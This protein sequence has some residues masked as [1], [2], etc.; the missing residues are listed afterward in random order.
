MGARDLAAF[1][2]GKC[3]FVRTVQL[4][5]RDK[6]DIPDNFLIVAIPQE[7]GVQV[8]QEKERH[9]VDVEVKDL[10]K[11]AGKKDLLKSCVMV[12]RAST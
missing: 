10:Q 4:V 9:Q 2:H 5:V 11:A 12:N 3:R 1:L 6:A 8:D 7:E